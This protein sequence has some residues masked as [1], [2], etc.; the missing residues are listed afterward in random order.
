MS[1]T[2]SGCH[3]ARPARRVGRPEPA[4]VGVAQGEFDQD[5]TGCLLWHDRGGPDDLGDVGVD[6]AGCKAL[7][8]GLICEYTDTTSS[9]GLSDSP[10]LI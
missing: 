3:R 2:A 6:I 10:N 8:E 9:Q 4:I 1:A 5:R 7:E